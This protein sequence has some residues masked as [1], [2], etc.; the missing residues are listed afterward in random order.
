LCLLWFFLL[1]MWSS[2]NICNLC[3]F[4]LKN[5]HLC[6]FSRTEKSDRVFSRMLL[7]RGGFVIFKLIPA[8]LCCLVYS[9]I[10]L[11]FHTTII[12]QG[13]F[14]FSVYF[15]SFMYIHML[16]DMRLPCA[17]TYQNPQGNQ[18]ENDPNNTTVR[19][20][21][22]C[23]YELLF[24]KVNWLVNLLAADICRGLGSKCDWWHFE[25]SV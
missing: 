2:V 1:S 17:A 25:S 10:S 12:L 9:I 19:S 23:W 13:S 16:F 8:W 11:D 3:F 15:S 21:F 14:A 7:R 4:T 5:N 6:N 18:G 24:V 20:W 22:Y